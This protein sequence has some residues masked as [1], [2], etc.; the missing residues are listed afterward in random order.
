MNILNTNKDKHKEK[1]TS[2]QGEERSIKDYLITIKEY[3]ETIKNMEIDEEKQYGI[4]KLE[5][6]KKQ[7]KSKWSQS[8]LISTDFICP[9]NVKKR[10]ITRKGY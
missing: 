10:V 7:K 2:E 1:W 8:L 5:R 9:K 3:V 4:Y 6:Y